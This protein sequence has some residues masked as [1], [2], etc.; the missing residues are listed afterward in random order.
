MSTAESF[1]PR[2]KADWI[3]SHCRQKPDDGGLFVWWQ[4][5]IVYNSSPSALARHYCSLV[6][7]L[8]RLYKQI[9][10]TNPLYNCN[11]ITDTE[12]SQE[13]INR[14]ARHP[15]RVIWEQFH[16]VIEALCVYASVCKCRLPLIKVTLDCALTEYQPEQQR[17]EHNS[18][19][20]WTHYLNDAIPHA[21]ISTHLEMEQ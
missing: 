20:S 17:L 19:A 16:D 8:Q 6:V 14:A 7:L 4:R 18:L 21:A 13:Y 10:Q 5:G 15:V 11:H 12:L 3:H 2:V 1:D 9:S